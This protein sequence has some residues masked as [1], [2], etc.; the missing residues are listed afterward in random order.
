MSAWRVSRYLFS[1]FDAVIPFPVRHL[2]LL[3]DDVFVVTHTDGPSTDH[4][5]EA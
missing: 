2:A 3:V 5:H 4:S 1:R